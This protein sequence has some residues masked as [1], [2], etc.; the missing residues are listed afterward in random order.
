MT[1]SLNGTERDFSSLNHSYR[2]SHFHL[3]AVAPDT[4]QDQSTTYGNSRRRRA[5][6]NHAS[7]H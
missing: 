5:R 6:S 4:V 2:R 1:N 3:V 7:W